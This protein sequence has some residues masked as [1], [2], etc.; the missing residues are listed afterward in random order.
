[1]G[2]VFELSP[3]TGGSWQTKPCCMHAFTGGQDGSRSDVGVTLDLKADLRG[4]TYAGGGTGC[5]G[6]GCGVVFQVN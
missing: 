3:E 1:M 5:G 2:S 6:N 4:T